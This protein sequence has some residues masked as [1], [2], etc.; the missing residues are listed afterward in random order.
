V[1]AKE[2]GMSLGEAAGI[3]FSH[4]VESEELR[5]IKKL[6]T[7]PVVFEGA[8]LSHEPHRIT[9]YL[10]E[11]AGLFHPYYN[12]YR[13]ITDEAE[14]SRARLGLCEAVRIVLRDGLEIL[15]LTAPEKM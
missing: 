14:L 7:Y 5:I 6:L 10:Q 9:F 1:K 11:L 4:L 13:V 3:D 12:K 2:Q 8:V 15:G